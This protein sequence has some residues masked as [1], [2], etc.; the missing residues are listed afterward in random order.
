M[1]FIMHEIINPGASHFA[2]TQRRLARFN[3]RRLEPGFVT[4]EWRDALAEEFE[5]LRLEGEFIEAARQEI[6]PLVADV[7]EEADRFVTWFERL[8]DSGPGQNDPLFPWLAR[9]ACRDEMAWFLTQEVAGEAGFDDLVA[10]AQVKIPQRAKLEM[11]RNYWDEMGRGNANGMHGPMLDRLSR[12]FGLAPTIER[13]L[14]EV[15]AL[16]NIMVGLACNRRY[17]FQAVGALGAIELTEPTRAIFVSEGLNRLGVSA[18]VRHY[19]ALHAVLD[20]KHSTAWDEEVL[21]SLVAEDSRRALPIAE[22][23]ILRLWCGARC[24]DGY[25]AEFKLATCRNAA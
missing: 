25:R 10:L 21:R 14:P 23:A 1:E 11:A 13:T 24:F 15:L 12:H 20:V 2:V 8:R 19:F 7:P 18:K 16:G 22:G 9:H 6:A 5:L 4:S 3:H 17:A